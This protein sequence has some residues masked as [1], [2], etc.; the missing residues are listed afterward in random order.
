MGG[1]WGR[2]KTRGDFCLI[3]VNLKT[4]TINIY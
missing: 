1:G 4:E 3:Y 2:G